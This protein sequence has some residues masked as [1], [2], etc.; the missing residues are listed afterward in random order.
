MLPQDEFATGR[1]T[2]RRRRAVT[3]PPQGDPIWWGWARHRTKPW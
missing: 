3:C 1:G 2:S